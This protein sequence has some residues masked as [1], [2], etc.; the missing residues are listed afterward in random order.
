[1]N[2][3]LLTEYF[4]DS[5]KGEFSGGVE[6]RCYFMARELSKEHNVKVVCSW[7]KGQ[8]RKTRMKG[9]EVERVGPHHAYSNKGGF[10][11]RIRFAFA[12]YN[13]IKKEKKYD[14]VD[15]Y[16]FTTY[17]PG[18]L[19]ARRIKA[20]TIATY[21][22]TWLG[23]WIKNKGLLT[24]LV[25]EILERT[26]LFFDWDT[27]VPVSNFTKQQLVKKGIPK[28]KMK[29]V[30][31][32]V[33]L[34]DFR[35]TRAKKSKKF[36]VVYVGRL[37]KTKRVETLI[38]AVKLVEDVECVIVGD[39]DDKQ[40]FKNL[41]KELGVEDKVRF[42]GFL[43]TK[44]EVIKEIKKAHVF[45]L[46][47]AVEGFGITVVEAM[48]SGIPVITSNI[49]PL[50]EV[51]GNGEYGLNFKLDNYKELASKIRFLKKDQKK[52]TEMKKKG[53]KRA[54]DFEW[55]NIAK[56]YNSKIINMGE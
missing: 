46:P 11:S 21:H 56:E 18:Y 27:I 3:L 39:G 14:Y 7:R 38:R 31:N 25:G 50:L 35:N 40:Y 47:S 42:T 6:A 28:Q 55:E 22:E 52:R 54:E 33:L 41:V 37:I 5:D 12:A 13:K 45:C 1:M 43:D 9:F 36:R 34:D 19:G 29:V 10:V 49:P 51:T 48:A 44:E 24:G 32:G 4:P 53:L 16:N 20:K 30:Y 17:I 8:K 23:E 2:I 15:S 26:A